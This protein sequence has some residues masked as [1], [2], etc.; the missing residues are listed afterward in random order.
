MVWDP[1]NR[2]WTWAAPADVE[3]SKSFESAKEVI[4]ALWESNVWTTFV[5]SR[6]CILSAVAKAK[7]DLVLQTRWVTVSGDENMSV[8]VLRAGLYWWIVLG[9]DRKR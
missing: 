4:G 7:D 5:D 9:D 3:A 6:I 1:S 8:N 2:L